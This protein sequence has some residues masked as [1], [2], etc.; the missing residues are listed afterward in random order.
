[1]ARA[2]QTN[3]A[4]ARRRY[5][6]TIAESDAEFET[7]DDSEAPAEPAARGGRPT[8]ASGAARPSL[9]A[10]FR[11]A[12][13]PAHLRED[14]RALPGLLTHAQPTRIPLTR[15]VIGIPWFLVS[16]LLVIIGFAALAVD[17]ASGAVLF[18]LVSL[19]PGGP[20]LPVLLVGF[21]ATRASY[22]QG[23]L[24]GL[25]DLVLI[26]IYVTIIPIGAP[27]T[28]SGLG[29]VLLSAA[30]TGL[31]TS[32]LFAGAAAWYRRF[33]QLSSPRRPQPAKGGS[34][35]Q[36]PGGRTSGRR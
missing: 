19:P 35:G 27:T 22:L 7:T 2:K 26:G 33:L 34:R 17:P 23:L 3:R 20:T 11:E 28:G 30:V 9:G 6:Q 24:I 25:L 1:L 5:R 18:Q 8:A 13:H 12:Y 31:P 15:T 10:A 21:M 4:E 16:A 36:R 32:I 14:L 29:E